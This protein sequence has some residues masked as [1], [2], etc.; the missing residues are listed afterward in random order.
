MTINHSKTSKGFSLVET[1]IAIAILLV[2]VVGPIGLI[3]NALHNLYYARDEMVAINLAQEGIEV[4]REIRDSNMLASSAGVPA[5]DAGIG[6]GEYIVSAA[7]ASPLT[8]DSYGA[9]AQAVNL[10]AQG[11]YV[12]DA[13]IT[14]QFKRLVTITTITSGSEIKVTSKVTWTTGGQT[15]TI[16]VSENLFKWALTP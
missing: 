13:G 9:V 1:L 10:D 11:F 14:T 6:A 12:Q 2:A 15:G 3:G 4:I 8:S 7:S 16:S 5:W